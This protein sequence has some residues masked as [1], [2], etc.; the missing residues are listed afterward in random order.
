MAH[1]TAIGDRWMNMA[2]F[3]FFAHVIMTF[4]ADMFRRRDQLIGMV[5]SMGIMA[6][7]TV[8]AGYRTVDVGLL[9]RGGIVAAETQIGRIRLER[10]LIIAL[11]RVVTADA[12][13]VQDRF[14][15]R[16]L[17]HHVAAGFMTPEAYFF[18]FGK[19]GKFV[20]LAGCRYMAH[21]ANTG[22]DWTMDICARAHVGM[23]VRLYTGDIALTERGSGQ[24]NH[25][26]GGQQH[27]VQSHHGIS[28]L[29]SKVVRHPVHKPTE[30]YLKSILENGKKSRRNIIPDTEVIRYLTEFLRVIGRQAEWDGIVDRNGRRY[31][32][33]PQPLSWCR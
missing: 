16:S 31:S 11:M 21:S 20:I 2:L 19:K 9:E 15:N 32:R 27:F 26:Y 33:R 6:G 12:I 10:V 1:R 8:T 18:L 22:P 29:M 13:P 17:Q 24:D 4:E 25:S 30:S 3:H 14:V 23:A 7:V 5:R 28:I